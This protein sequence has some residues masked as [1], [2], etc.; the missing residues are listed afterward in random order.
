[1]T[2]THSRRAYCTR[3]KIL[4]V[5]FQKKH[6]IGLVFLLVSTFSWAQKND[7]FDIKRSSIYYPQVLKLRKVKSTR[8]VPKLIWAE[9][10]FFKPM[11]P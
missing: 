5:I 10:F 2:L 3:Y 1:M 4:A 6:L 9:K 7:D 11:L 8:I